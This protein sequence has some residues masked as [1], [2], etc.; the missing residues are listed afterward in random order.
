MA[1]GEKRKRLQAAWQSCL[2]RLKTT[3]GWDSCSSL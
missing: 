3:N 2:Q 1:M